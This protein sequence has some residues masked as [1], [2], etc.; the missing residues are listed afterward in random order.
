[1]LM[2]GLI[3]TE[4]LKVLSTALT[5]FVETQCPIQVEETGESYEVRTAKSMLDA[6]DAELSLRLSALTT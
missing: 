4:E 2:P 6:I 3:H 5:Q 1:M